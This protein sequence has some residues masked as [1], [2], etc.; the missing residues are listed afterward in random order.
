MKYEARVVELADT[1]GL[2]PCASRL[3]GSTPVSGTTIPGNEIPRPRC[4]SRASPPQCTCTDSAN[5]TSL[6][7]KPVLGRAPVKP[8]PRTA[9]PY[10]SGMDS[11]IRLY[12]SPRIARVSPRIARVHDS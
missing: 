12:G 11:L 10:S 2:G 5:L 6:W 3:A 7:A 1:H 9:R 4:H 8:H